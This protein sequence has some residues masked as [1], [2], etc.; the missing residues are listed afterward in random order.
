MSFLGLKKWPTPV[1]KPMWPFIGSGM[2]LL[3]GIWHVQQNAVRSEAFRNDPRNP[4][5]ARIA[6]ESLH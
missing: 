2:F 5:A 4:Y 3:Y 1:F 6:K